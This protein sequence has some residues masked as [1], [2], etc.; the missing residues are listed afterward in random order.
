[1]KPYIVGVAGGTGAGKSTLAF[2]LQDLF[3]G[4]VTILHLDDYFKPA[5]QVQEIEG[6]KVWD[7][8]ESLFL[9]KMIAD[10]KKLRRGESAEV[11][12]KSPRLNP[13]FYE[14]Y[15][16]IPVRHDAADIIVVEGFLVLAIPE[17]R[18]QLDLKIYLDA[19]FEVHLSRRVHGKVHN[20]PPEYDRKILKPMH[21]RYVV[22]SK[23]HADLVLDCQ[24]K[25]QREVLEAV[26]EEIKTHLTT[27]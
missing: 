23:K 6:M 1:M 7:H 26:A 8:P 27:D 17:I 15:K 25:S 4:R 20:F 2:G 10:L 11:M 16:R 5:D 24:R 22:N 9:N 12:T 3:T 14:T 18:E 19:P 13:T 21:D